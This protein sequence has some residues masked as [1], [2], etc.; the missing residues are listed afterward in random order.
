MT[1]SDAAVVDWNSLSDWLRTLA[2]VANLL[3]VIYLYRVSR[4]DRIIDRYAH[5]DA[6][7]FQEF[8]ISPNKDSLTKNFSRIEELVDSFVLKIRESGTSASLSEI[9][10]IKQAHIRKFNRI[11][12]AL[13]NAIDDVFI[14]DDNLGQALSQNV[15]DLQDEIT[16]GFDGFDK[17]LNPE[18]LKSL[19]VQVQRSK[20]KFL[21]NLYAGHKHRVVQE[22][23]KRAV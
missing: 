9:A 10:K 11:K 12:A 22:E 8:V 1:G 4:R 13:S 3:L 23:N 15:Q 5:V 2:S 17:M 16:N 19:S 7:W 6:F 18:D 14:V 20:K 21:R